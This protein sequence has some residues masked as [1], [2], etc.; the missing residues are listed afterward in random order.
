[1]DGGQL[2]ATISDFGL[3]SVGIASLI[4]VPMSIVLIVYDN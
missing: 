4:S 2:I 3:I 1:M